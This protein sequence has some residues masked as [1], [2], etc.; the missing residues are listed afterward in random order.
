MRFYG[1][2]KLEPGDEAFV[3]IT[4]TTPVVLDVGDRFVLREAG[5]RRDGRGRRRARRRASRESRT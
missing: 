4:A 1:T 5:R 3:R 2:T